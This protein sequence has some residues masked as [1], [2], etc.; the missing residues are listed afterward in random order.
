MDGSATGHIKQWSLM[1]RSRTSE[2]PLLTDLDSSVWHRTWRDSPS[3]EI[4]TVI[5]FLSVCCTATKQPMIELDKLPESSTVLIQ[6]NRVV[7]VPRLLSVIM[8]ERSSSSSSSGQ[9]YRGGSSLPQTFYKQRV[10]D[11]A[12]FHW[13]DFNL[14]DD[15]QSL[16]DKLVA[17][18]T[19]QRVLN[20]I[21][22]I[23]YHL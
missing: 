3:S 7:V 23:L 18:K 1:T 20:D 4:A 6:Q 19:D 10:A 11:L 5:W 14:K 13:S 15:P 22:V 16:K 21:K 2:M 9:E 8:M 17:F 12:S